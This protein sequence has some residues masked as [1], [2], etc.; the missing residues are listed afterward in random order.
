MLRE[1][2]A[3]PDP[4]EQTTR[5]PADSGATTGLRPRS[6]SARIGRSAQDCAVAVNT[7]F[8]A[9]VP[10]GRGERDDRTGDRTRDWGRAPL[11]ARPGGASVRPALVVHRGGRALPHW[12]GH[13]E[14]LRADLPDLADDVGMDA[15]RRTRA[16]RT[17]PPGRE[18]ARLPRHRDR[19]PGTAGSP[20]RAGRRTGRRGAVPQRGRPLPAGQAG[21]DHRQGRGDRVDSLAVRHRPAAAPTHRPP[22]PRP[23][24]PHR[25]QGPGRVGW[26][27]SGSAGVG[28]DGEG[29]GPPEEA[30]GG[31]A[32]WAG[33]R[34]SRAVKLGSC[35]SSW[36][37]ARP[38]A[39]P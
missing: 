13:R 32:G 8:T 17:R 25:P 31:R 14:V 39:T 26:G 5:R 24:V 38:R 23:A 15:H 35:S 7:G 37:R 19:R 27:R 6:H 21:E 36:H 4:H 34:P 1:H 30:G 33:Q 2:A 28:A 9:A 11:A 20:G 18:T 16:D 12:R 3:A 29:P 22:Y 10:E